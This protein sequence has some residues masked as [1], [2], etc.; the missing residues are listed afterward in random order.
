MGL[1]GMRDSLTYGLT[2]TTPNVRVMGSGHTEYN[3][4]LID[5]TGTLGN[6]AGADY[7]EKLDAHFH[8]PLGLGAG[9]SYGWD[10]TRIHGA[11]DW[12]A[13]VPNY[14]VI[15]SPPFVVHKPSGDST[16]VMSITDRLT[17]VFNWGLG[18]EHRFSTWSG[19]AS[20][21]TDLS[22]RERGDP[23]SHSV[24]RWNLSDVATGAIFRIWRSDLALGLS[25]AFGSQPTLPPA[26]PIGGGTP[27][28]ENLKTHETLVTVLVGWKLNF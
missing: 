3:T 18:I 22:G 28:P 27:V 5:Q 9:A 10:G 23:P 13:E 4:T 6:V 7:Q 8:T 24:T 26:Q 20:Y 2:L 16:V 11:I 1:S 19:Y 12:N 17:E 21:H 15:E 14:T 25:A